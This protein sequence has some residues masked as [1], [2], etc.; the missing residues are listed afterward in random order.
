MTNV[1]DLMAYKNGEYVPLKDI[2]PSILDFGFIH[3]DAT[4]DVMPVYNGKAFC[5]ERHLQRFRNSAERYGLTIPDINPL[6]IIK[7]LAKRNPIENAFV[8]FII[9]R[10]FPPSGNP[11]DIENCPVNFAMYIKPSY[12]LSI[13]GNTTVKVFLDEKSFRVDDIHYGQEYKNMSWIDLT[14]AQRNVP[15]GYDTCVLVD[16]NGNITEGPGF[17]VG[18]VDSLGIQTPRRN[19]L[20]GITMSVVEDIAKEQ[21]ISFERTDIHAEDWNNMDEIFL[22]SSS[23]GITPVENGPITEMLIKEYEARKVDDKYS[24]AL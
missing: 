9:W 21:N 15:E 16:N 2:G 17:N 7:E 4:Y 24:T 1:L 12:P 14:I 5:Y 23:G 13:Q 10:G 19:C 8:W 18:F 22:T 20:K 6:E 3:C 11:R